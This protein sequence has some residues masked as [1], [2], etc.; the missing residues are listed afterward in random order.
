MSVYS[1]IARVTAPNPAEKNITIE[2]QCLSILTLF[3]LSDLHRCPLAQ[4]PPKRQPTRTR[5]RKEI[6]THTLL[7]F[8]CL[9]SLL[10]P[11]ADFRLFV[12]AI[13]GLSKCGDVDGSQ[14]LPHHAFGIYKQANFFGTTS[15]VNVRL[16]G[17]KYFINHPL[18]SCLRYTYSCSHLIYVWWL[19]FGI[20]I[21]L[22]SFNTNNMHVLC[23]L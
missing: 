19:Y 16:E 17:A 18:P 11:G 20:I 3:D 5:Q 23:F 1:A 22:F 14:V 8:P 7:L 12:S 2:P 6:R 15:S 13:L 10:S 9:S 21:R 4:T